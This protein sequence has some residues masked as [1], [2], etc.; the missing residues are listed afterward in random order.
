MNTYARETF[1]PAATVSGGDT[2]VGTSGAG[3]GDPM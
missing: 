2:L 1:T 3:P